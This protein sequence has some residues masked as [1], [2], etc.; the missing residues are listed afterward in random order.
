MSLRLRLALLF[1]AGTTA[2]I[3]VAGLAFL[4][5]LRAS[6]N[7][8]LDATLQPRAAALARQV[9]RAKA[10]PL[11]GPGGDQQGQSS[12]ADAVT[13]VLTPA[14]V[15][16]S[17]SQAAGNRP[18]LTGAALRQASDG[19]VT[20][21]AAIEGERVRILAIRAHRGSRVV[22]VLAGASTDI[23]DAAQARAR[24]VILA[25]GPPAV[26]V[27]GLGAW[28]LT[29]AALRPVARMRRR[30]ADISEDNSGARLPVPATHDE[31]AS[32]AVTMNSLLDR[33]QRAL[34]RQRGFVA[35]A[36]H[37]LRTPLT[38]LKAELELAA[39]PGRSRQAL[40][41][42]VAAAADDTDRLIRLAEDLL[43]LARADEGA[44]FL[45]PQRIDVSDVL[46][47]AVG[48]LAAQADAREIT[49]SLDASRPLPAVADPD[50]LRQALDNL[51]H[52]AIRHSPRGGA[53]E[54]TGRAGT[55]RSSLSV[56]IEVCDHGPGFPPEFLPRAFERFSRA[57]PAR[58]R[59]D[60]GTGL[61]L[62]IVAFIA[63][64]HGGRALADNRSQGGARVRIELPA[65]P[66]PARG[67]GT[68]EQH[69]T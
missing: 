9:A 64:A 17:A 19:S 58:S 16:L 60:G 63:H 24:M 25:A 27:A 32:L 49:V 55:R 61:G 37:E 13:Q 33:L 39:R 22:V 65:R 38:A 7:A 56:V 14:G 46:S 5:Q 47:A 50:R 23:A 35:D 8:A 26:A 51:I 15:V 69:A 2:V 18:L 53:V 68:A 52:N 40:A 48:G 11:P 67:A 57:D 54:V 28:L 43:L 6:L 59:A 34:A 45:H 29:G 21:T 42:A 1:A 36:G 12:G 30:L 31:I 44:A 3:T 41:A 10:L 62:A 4:G 20:V 66:V